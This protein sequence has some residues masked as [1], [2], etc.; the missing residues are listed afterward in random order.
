MLPRTGEFSV[1]YDP[2][3]EEVVQGT[4]LT[5]LFVYMYVYVCACIRIRLR[6]RYIYTCLPGGI[7]TQV[8]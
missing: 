3:E 2:T 1:L 8:G 4:S 5:P 6:C 7:G